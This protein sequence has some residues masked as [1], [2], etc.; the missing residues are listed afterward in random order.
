MHFNRYCIIP[1]LIFLAT[2]FSFSQSQAI[3]LSLKYPRS[4]IA[5]GMGSQGVTSMDPS[6]ALQYNPANL[7]YS[8]SLSVSFFNNPW[9]I[10]GSAKGSVRNRLHA[11]G[12]RRIFY[13]VVLGSFYKPE[14]PFFRTLDLGGILHTDRQRFDSRR[15]GA[16]RV[17][18]C[19]A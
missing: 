5:E 10:L 3:F 6:V 19:P 8:G 4:I 1:V 9:N 18:S 14:V 7:Y 13:D 16:V 15:A 11:Y 17:A 2:G 12:F